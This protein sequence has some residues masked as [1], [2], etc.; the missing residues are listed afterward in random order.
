MSDT[1]LAYA[2]LL[3]ADNKFDLAR[4][5][6]ASLLQNDPKNADLVYSMALLS[7]QG[8]LPTD[9]RTYL[10]RYLELIASSDNDS[11]RA[12]H[13]PPSPH[14]CIWHKLPRIKSIFRSRSNGCAR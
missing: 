14:I 2:R 9:A 6:F 7:M 8:K 1:R 3:I 10:Q 13:A 4:A 11:A 5:Q 12:V